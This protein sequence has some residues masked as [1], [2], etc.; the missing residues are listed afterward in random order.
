VDTVLQRKLGDL[1]MHVGQV[2]LVGRIA[3][4]HLPADHQ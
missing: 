3:A 1:F 4:A 2:T